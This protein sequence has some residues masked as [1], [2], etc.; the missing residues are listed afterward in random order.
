[1]YTEIESWDIWMLLYAG[2]S[3]GPIFPNSWKRWKIEI[4][5][6][7]PIGSTSKF[8]QI[9]KEIENW[10]DWVL[11]SNPQMNKKEWKL[12]VKFLILSEQ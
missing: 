12:E 2:L 9:L 5:E 6:C 7:W 3:N 11:K 4:F 10:D 8:F 1:M